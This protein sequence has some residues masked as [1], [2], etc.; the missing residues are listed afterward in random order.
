MKDQRFKPQTLLSSLWIFILFNM[1]LRDMHQFLNPQFMDEL[2]TQNISEELVLMFGIILEIPILMVPLSL[3][4]KN[5]LNKWTNIFA[6]CIALLGISYSLLS[7]DLDDFF[8][9]AMEIG[10]LLTIVRT[11]FKLSSSR[12]KEIV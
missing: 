10:A 9:A 7:A 1:L 8:F 2:I 4:L 5:R 12:V 6:S 11:A 3:T